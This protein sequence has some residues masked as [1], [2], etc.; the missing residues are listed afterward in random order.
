MCFL[1]VVEPQGAKC[2]GITERWMTGK[3]R[4]ECMLRP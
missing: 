1:I 2:D 4:E 3:G